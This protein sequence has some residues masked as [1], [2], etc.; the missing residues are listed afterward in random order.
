MGLSGRSICCKLPEPAK[1]HSLVFFY[2]H[3]QPHLT[4]HL[5]F[6]T[7]SLTIPHAVLTPTILDFRLVYPQ[8]YMEAAVAIAC[9]PE[10]HKFV[11]W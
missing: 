8:V 5:T 11:Y 4:P 9:K 10:R 3:Y 7:S 1:D 6:S 2:I